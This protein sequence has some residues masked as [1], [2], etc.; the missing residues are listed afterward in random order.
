MEGSKSSLYNKN[1]GVYNET[2][3]NL[4]TVCGSA[5]NLQ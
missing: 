2:D 3:H 1:L 5:F 4:N